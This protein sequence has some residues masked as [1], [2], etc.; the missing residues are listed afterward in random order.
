MNDVKIPVENTNNS[1]LQAMIPFCV[2]SGCAR[3]EMLSLTVG[4]FIYATSNYHNSYDI[5]LGIETLLDKGSV[6]PL[7]H[8]IRH[9]TNTPY[10]CCCSTVILKERLQYKTVHNDDKL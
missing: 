6:I 9:K 7:F 5:W 8:I 2:S 10:Y 4:E 3:K 1:K